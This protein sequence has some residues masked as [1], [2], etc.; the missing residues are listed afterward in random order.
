MEAQFPSA[1]TNEYSG[2]PN[3]SVC[4]A[5]ACTA[6]GYQCLAPAECD[7]AQIHQIQKCDESGKSCCKPKPANPT[8]SVACKTQYTDITISIAGLCVPEATCS[9]PTARK[10]TA[11]TACVTPNPTCCCSSTPTSTPPPGTPGTT[12][13]PP[14]TGTPP[15]ASGSGSGNLYGASEAKGG[16]LGDAGSIPIFLGNIAGAALSLSGSLFLVLII[17]G[18]ILIMSAA[19]NQGSIDKGKKIITWAIIGALILAGAYAITTMV[20][21]ALGT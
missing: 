9:D 2:D 5:P 3:K 15:P 7:P 4:C 13:P 11:A 12:T 8:C 18:G 10:A 6:T 14:G 20:F 16:L 1:C 17:W 21:T 19:G